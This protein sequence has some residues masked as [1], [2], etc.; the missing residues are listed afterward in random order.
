MAGLLVAPIPMQ[1]CVAIA[2]FRRPARLIIQP[3]GSAASDLILGAEALNRPPLPCF[4]SIMTA[5]HSRFVTRHPTTLELK[6]KETVPDGIRRIICERIDKA[7]D[8]LNHRTIVRDEAVH[9]A[10]KRFKEVRGVL[11]L[12]RS[13]LGEKQFSREN[14]TF[15]DA[16]RPLS[17][18]RDAR[19]LLDTLDE[20][21]ARY[22][23]TRSSAS[24]KHL[25]LTLA[26]RRR[27]IRRRVFKKDR[28]TPSIVREVRASSRRVGKWSLRR[29][30]W[31]AIA[32]GLRETY[33]KCREAM[34]AA[35]RDSD[36]ES[37]HEWRKRTKILRYEIELLA[38]AFPDVME[39]MAEASHRLTHLLGKDHDLAVLQQLL[40][41]ELRPVADTEREL[42][43]P[44]VE[45][46]RKELLKEGRDLGRKLFAENDEEFVRRIHG[47]W[48]AWR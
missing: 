27:E 29:K 16:G 37:L 33:G 12:V 7:L 41:N 24:F 21:A 15:R 8:V 11:R 40:E 48:K 18:L 17:Q 45:Q 13:E 10:R 25:R 4:Y 34:H 31:K 20:L 46:R 30:G 36:D 5:F 2:K 23:I 39:P 38:R 42:L 14:R 22:G 1:R 28:A 9:E 32:D 43:K 47:Y 44:L 19:V 6:R 26:A 3:K 35:L